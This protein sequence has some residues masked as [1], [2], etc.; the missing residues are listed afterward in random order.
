MTYEYLKGVGT[1]T[2]IGTTVDK[3]VVTV[4]GTVEFEGDSYNVNAIAES[5]FKNNPNK[6]KMTK[7]KI[8]ENIAEIGANAFQG[9]SN[10]KL[11]WLPSSLTSL[12]EKAFDG[13]KGITHVSSSIKSPAEN[14]A[15]YF[16]NNATLYV[17]K[18]GKDNYNVSGWNNFS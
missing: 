13:C 6:D 12:G 1:A 4:D 10:L 8:S 11:V 18:G 2:L 17:P 7:L 5:V 3:E 14:E 9:C 15:N 16:P